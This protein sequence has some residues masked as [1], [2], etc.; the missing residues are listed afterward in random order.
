MIDEELE[1]KILT[2]DSN[3][4]NRN[5]KLDPKGYFIIKVDLT[6]RLIIVEHYLNNI[7]LKGFALDPI[8]NKPIRCDS[9]TTREFSEI[10]YGKTAKEIGIL[11]TEEREDL[12]SK[13]DHSLYL[14]RELQKAEKCLLENTQYIQD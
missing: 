2:I 9:K 4:S 12:I 5:I 11:I 14:G 13:F 10:F 6:K 1:K 3:L 7:D 8:T